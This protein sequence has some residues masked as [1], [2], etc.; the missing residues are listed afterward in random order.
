MQFRCVR[1]CFHLNQMWEPGMILDAEEAP[2]HFEAVGG[3]VER[4]ELTDAPVPGTPVPADTPPPRRGGRRK[5]AAKDTLAA[6]APP[7]AK[8]DPVSL[9]DLGM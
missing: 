7:E 1:R 2:R 4:Q 6:H 5:G 8:A 9:G 3:K